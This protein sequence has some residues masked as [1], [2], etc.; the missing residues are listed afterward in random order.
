MQTREKQI[1][2]RN[3]NAV[4]GQGPDS[5][6]IHTT[7]Y[8]SCFADMETPS[9]QDSSP[10]YAARKHIDLRLVGTKRLM[11]KSSETSIYYLTINQSEE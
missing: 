11:I 2:K 7:V 10:G 1:V 5:S 8:L 6:S 4:L 3:S 9:R